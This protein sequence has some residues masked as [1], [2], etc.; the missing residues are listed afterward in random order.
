MIKQVMTSQ[1][2]TTLT[3]CIFLLIT[4]GL[5]LLFT[6]DDTAQEAYSQ[7]SVDNSPSLTLPTLLNYS[8]SK[9][10]AQGYVDDR[11]CSNCH[12][13]HSQTFQHVGMSHSFGTPAVMKKIENFTAQPFYHAKSNRY[14]QITQ[15]N[16][17][18][19]FHRY[20]L[21]E[22][23][24]KINEW[25]R[26]IDYVVGSG[27]TS[28]SYLYQNNLGELF[29]LP[30][31]WYSQTQQWQMAPGFDKAEHAGVNRPVQRQCMFCHNA[32]PEVEVNSD[33]HWQPHIFPKS[34]PSGIGCQRCHGPGA[35]HIDKVLNPI[36][37]EPLLAI[38]EAIVNPAKLPADQRDSV[39]F[40]CHMQPSAHLSGIRKLE[41][42]DYSFRPG[43][44][45]ND[46]LIHVDVVEQGKKQDDKFQINHHGYRLAQSECFKQSNSELTCISC[47]NPHQKPNK[48]DKNQHFANVCIDCHQDAAA[49]APHTVNDKDNC[50]GCHMPRRRTQ[51][52]VHVV[53]TDHKIQ[54]F[55][56]KGDSQA[57]LQEVDPVLLDMNFAWP[58]AAPQGSEGEMY[59][60]ITMLRAFPN[61]NYLDYLTAMIS[62]T[63]DVP[64]QAYF[65]LAQGQLSLQRYEQALNTVEIILAEQPDNQR[66]LMWKALALFALGDNKQ[67]AAIFATLV[68]QKSQISEVYFN[69][70]LLHLKLNNI[71]QAQKLLNKTVSLKEN[72][73]QAW[74]YLAL[75]AD[76]NNQYQLAIEHLQTALAIEPSYTKAYKKIIEYYTYLGDEAQARRYTE[77]ALKYAAQPSSL[78]VK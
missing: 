74:Y 31:S 76:K 11:L 62:R 37:E 28:R 7:E 67:S 16:E 40:Q 72:M 48:Q 70:A 59:K 14:Y 41:R 64:I 54:R 32:F 38:R 63:E 43:E 13:Q 55:L 5:T 3:I 51:D 77:H 46:Y 58:H 33:L 50:I 18:L 68:E 2:K 69:Y 15:E 25:T 57:E 29:Q 35:E 10:A 73:P 8:V 49:V 56:P 47:H 24:N 23:G 52:V 42:A 66:A 12:A 75:V 34:L 71:S 21:D 65:D 60:A 19:I 27:N 20:Q 22:Q 9:G 36:D 6:G 53:M 78:S 30:L 39:C 17:Q 4:V 1:L 44:N 61:A 45:L 26:N